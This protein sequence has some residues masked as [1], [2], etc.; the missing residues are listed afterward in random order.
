MSFPLI[1]SIKSSKIS[2]FERENI[3][4]YK[5]FWIILFKR[6]ILNFNQTIINQSI[7][8]LIKIYSALRLADNIKS[9]NIDSMQ[10]ELYKKEFK[11]FNDKIEKFLDNDLNTPGV[12]GVFFDIVRKFNLISVNKKITGESK[13]FAENFLKLFNTYGDILG[14]FQESKQ[15]FVKELN[16]LM[17]RSKSIDLSSIEEK[18]LIRNKART[19]KNYEL[20]DKLRD[21]LLIEGIE[22]KDNPD[23]ST[24]WSVK[25]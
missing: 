21:E 22:L 6:N 4:K 23:G 16:I 20:S 9:S 3:K 13:Y 15:D 8:N 10:S 19:S 1:I 11:A 14:L 2:K 18:I 12:F 7:G 24:D 5:P 25:I 17:L